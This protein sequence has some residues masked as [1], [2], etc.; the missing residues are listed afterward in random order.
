LGDPEAARDEGRLASIDILRGIAIGWVVLF[1]LWGDLEFFP[2][3]PRDYYEQLAWQVKHGEGPWRVFTAFTDLIFRD[4]FQGVPLFMMIS[5]LSLTIAAYRAGDALAWPKFFAQ[6]FRKLLVPYWAGVV[7]TYGVMALIA[8]RQVSIGGGGFGDH[9]ANGVS[10]SLASRINVDAG[11]VFASFALIPRLVRDEWFFAP[12]LALW[13]VGLLAQYYLLF[14]LLFVLMKRIGVVPFLVV[15]FGA[16]VMANWWEISRYGEPELQF[17]LVTGWAPFRLFEFTAGM[18]IG[19]LLA[20]PD[21]HPALRFARRPAVIACALLAG[22]AAHTAGDLLIGRWS[23]HYWQALALPLVTLGIA[24]LALPLLVK[25]PGGVEVTLP[26][27]GLATVGVMS[28]GILIVSDAM[29]LVA[30]QLRLEGI[31][32]GAWWAFLVAVYVPVTMLVAWPLSRVL[33]LMPR[34]STTVRERDVRRTDGELASPAN[35]PAEV[36]VEPTGAGGGA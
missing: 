1:H 20:S 2:P 18:A 3:V 6:R 11:V 17:R 32:D 30:S 24:L 4:G 16:T 21:R 26:M 12:Q 14:P 29:R 28:Y 33:G 19:W 36:A 15:T 31:G 34:R 13:F 35:A 8:W 23:V 25:R 10:I 9:F 5:G 22:F 7:L 27:R